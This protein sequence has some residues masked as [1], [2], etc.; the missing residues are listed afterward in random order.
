MPVSTERLTAE[1]DE[2]HSGQRLD[3]F[4]SDRLPG[5]SRTR[6]QALIRQGRVTLGPATIEDVKYSVKPGD[7]FS[8]SVPPAVSAK[9]VGQAIPLNVVYEDDA[10]I[11]IDKPAGLVVHPGA[12]NIDRTLVNALIAHCGASL[13][14]IGGVARPGIVHRLDKDTS[15]L[16]VVAKTDQAHR[17]LSDQFADHGREGSLERG[18]L[19]LV[20]GAPPRPHGT[21]KAPI[22]RHKTSRTKMAVV[23]VTKGGREAVTHYQVLA[24]FGRGG[25]P[26]ASLLECLLETG[27]T[28]Q[29]RVH[30]A[31]IGTPLIG[32]PVYGTGFKSKLRKL[33]Q[34]A[35]D[36]LASFKRQALH[37][38]A[39]T[40]VHPLT[41]TLLE[42]NSPLPDDFAMI[43]EAL[44]EL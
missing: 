19:A 37:A 34:A 5:L 32:D 43:V 25:E 39:L 33:P 41:G 28:H 4:L 9:P 17:A 23:P 15:G 1:A 10:I 29:V 42:F 44:K 11:V 26:I 20:W 24:T 38:A 12:G 8:I 14:G 22:G 16:V 35:Q 2:S 27:R 30:L 3:R 13:S 36:K 31:S 7:R 21:I 40:F 18:Y 6:L